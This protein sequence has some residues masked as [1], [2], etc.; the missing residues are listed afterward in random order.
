MRKRHWW[1][2]GLGLLLVLTA[3]G[4][5]VAQ[6]P[7]GPPSS[8]STEVVSE[9][10][11]ENGV[12][13]GPGCSARSA[14]EYVKVSAPFGWVKGSSEGSCNL[15]LQWIS[16]HGTLTVDGEEVWS[17][18]QARSFTRSV[19]VQSGWKFVTGRPVSVRQQG[20]LEFEDPMYG[21]WNPRPTTSLT[22]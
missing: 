2:C 7:D 20:D 15:P 22:Y 1:F 12:L 3:V 5:A 6:G 9:Q 19:R 21:G 4:P 17:G 8:S 18:G 10:L 11:P 16:V 14:I 13:W